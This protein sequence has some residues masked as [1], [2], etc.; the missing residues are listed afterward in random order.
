MKV[1]FLDVPAFAK[2]DM[3]DAFAECGIESGLFMHEKYKERF[4]QDYEEAF[5]KKVE[6]EKYDFVFSFN[7]YP[8]LSK[9]CQKHNLKYVSYVY[10]SPLVALYSCTILN[11]CN[12]VFIFD[13]VTYH[14]LAKEGIKTVHY[15]PLA[16]NVKRLRSISCPKDVKT[17]LQS[18]VS[19]VGSLY[20][21]EHNFFERLS[22]GITDFTRG[23]LEGLMA[24]QQELYGCFLLE[25]LLTENIIA[26][27][28]K[29]V[30]YVPMPDGVESPAYVYANYFLAR[31]VTSNERISLLKRISKNYRLKL[32]THQ[33]S[34]L[35]PK[36]DFA[37][38]VDPYHS[39]PL[40]FKNS[41]INLNISLRSIQSGIPLR[42]MDIMG[43]GGFLLTNFQ[44]DFLDY[45]VPE[46]D[47]IYYESEED[48]IS[49]IEY[50][51]SH[52][53]KRRQIAANALGK[54]EESHTFVHR[55]MEILDIVGG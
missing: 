27:M 32:F 18:E 42:C 4:D 21:E 26:D 28:Q 52:E 30:P 29:A 15:L 7:Y 6:E 5:D 55:A 49:K 19:F 2:Q 12:Y 43:A 31:K 40:I 48:C 46:E 9:C 35:L 3:I 16:A 23:Y 45:F 44:A 47:F 25:E 10:D 22:A 41:K 54:M 24:A 53:T 1:L 34:K 14:A 8:I 37:G 51:L 38:S 36:A 20:N 13:R 39:L 17:K 50:Y 33:P 11:P